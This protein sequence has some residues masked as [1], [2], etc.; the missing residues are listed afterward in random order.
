MRF[1]DRQNETQHKHIER[2]TETHWQR[3][4]N[5]AINLKKILR[6]SRGTS[7]G[8]KCPKDRGSGEERYGSSTQRISDGYEVRLRN[9]K[10]RH[11]E[12]VEGNRIRTKP[13]VRAEGSYTRKT[14]KRDQINEIKQRATS[15]STHPAQTIRGKK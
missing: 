15:R 3:G 5:A 10:N 4:E 14:R 11:C 13:E 1:R 8:A 9:S 2:I 12:R 7:A 6:R